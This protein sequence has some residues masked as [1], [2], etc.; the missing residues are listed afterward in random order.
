M[1]PY[2][3]GA[4]NGIYIIDLQQTVRM[5]KT[6]Y[7]FVVDTVANGESILFVGTKKQARD[8]IYEEANRCEMFYVHNRWLGGM[9]TNFE[10]IKK[11][12]ERLKYL[13]GIF[14]DGSV[15]RFPKKE[16]LR[17]DK[18]RG[19]LDNNLGGIRE[20]QKLPGAMFVVDAKNENIAVREARRLGIPVVAIVDTNCNPDEIDYIIP[21]NDD[22]IRAIRLMTS[23]IAD[24]CIQGREQM[25]ERLQA[26]SDKAAYEVGA[27]E[28]IAA[29]GPGERTVVSDGSDGPI[30]E[31]ITRE[32]PVSKQPDE[33]DKGEAIEEEL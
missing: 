25:D 2:I 10:T 5:F 28:G 8:S 12:I 1:K 23:R 7:Q 33:D 30:V 11:G 32:Q 6:A 4:R 24:A 29:A 14:A 16:R 21:G 15:N 27:V 19:K 31:V 26:E 13:T 3:F 22:A 18:E 17:L 20:M 9:L